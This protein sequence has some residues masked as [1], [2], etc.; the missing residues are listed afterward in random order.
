MI[1]VLVVIFVNN[2]NIRLGE[3]LHPYCSDE[4][5]FKSNTRHHQN[6]LEG[7]KY[8]VILQNVCQEGINIE[9]FQNLKIPDKCKL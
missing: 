8:T 7:K 3:D 6:A 1:D 5:L 4:K 2:I 9:E